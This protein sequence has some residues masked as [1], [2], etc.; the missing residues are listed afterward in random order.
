MPPTTV[1]QSEIDAMPAPNA[2]ELDM[3]QH[4]SWAT[5]V[6]MYAFRQSVTLD[7]AGVD[8]VKR[9]FQKALA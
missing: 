9:V 2:E 4:M 1:P 5:A 8:R 7:I 6:R 3:W